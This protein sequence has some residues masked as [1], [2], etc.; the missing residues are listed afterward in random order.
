MKNFK[1]LF[2]SLLS[3]FF[4]FLCFRLILSFFLEYKLSLCIS[5]FSSILA[6]IFIVKVYSAKNNKEKTNEH[7]KYEKENYILQLD[8]LSKT[9]QK[10]LFIKAFTAKGL[11]PIKQKKY[12]FLPKSKTL[13]LIKFGAE[14]VTK[15]DVVS[16]Y[17]FGGFDKAF[18][19]CTEFDGELLRFSSRFTPKIILKDANYAYNLL[20]ETDCLPKIKFIPLKKER[21]KFFSAIKLKKHA[22]KFFIFGV[23]FTLFSFISSLKTYYL[24]VGIIFICLSLVL[25]L[26]GRTEKIGQDEI[27]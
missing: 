5:F 19:I 2:T 6:L 12:I 27:Y 3:A 24:S 25:A 23:L 4:C 10:S 18:I 1:L 17:N 20:K 26:F 15:A 22:K 9:E 21:F 14:K 11:S 13:V 7:Q 8:F 16:I